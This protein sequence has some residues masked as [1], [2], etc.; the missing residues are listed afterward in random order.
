MTGADGLCVNSPAQQCHPPCSRGAGRLIQTF[1]GLIH[2]VIVPFS[3]EQEKREEHQNWKLGNLK[4]F[5]A[6]DT[7]DHVV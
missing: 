2:F 1:V 4:F 7:D 5:S 6:P 3:G